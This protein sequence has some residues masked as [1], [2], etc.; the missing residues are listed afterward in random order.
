MSSPN[1]NSVATDSATAADYVTTPPKGTRKRFRTS[2][3]FGQH[4]A[5]VDAHADV[6][7]NRDVGLPALP[8][9]A[10][11]FTCGGLV[12][13]AADLHGVSFINIK[14]V[15][16][17]QRWIIHSLGGLIQDMPKTKLVQELRD[18][19][20]A[21]RGKRTRACFA[22]A[23]DGQ[24]LDAVGNV[25]VR[26]F[27]FQTVLKGARLKGPGMGVYLEHRL[28]VLQWF[29]T[30][31]RRD[32]SSHNFVTAQ[33]CAPE[34]EVDV[35]DVNSVISGVL[36]SR[37]ELRL[38]NIK[39]TKTRH[40]FIVMDT[41]VTT[42]VRLPASFRI[43]ICKVA[44]HHEELD[45]EARDTIETEVALQLERAQHFHDTGLILAE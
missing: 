38:N 22:V 27:T 12:V 18:A 7:G 30:E 41:K 13:D 8:E 16:D 25:T 5:D 33:Q 3:S 45:E 28:D 14:P 23:K 31:I 2:A 44:R 15:F 36:P 42:S 11:A 9:L 1:N 6:I 17:K 35:A 32:I 10:D 40:Q 29:L 34:D 4:D 20:A 19:I 37:D 39:Y 43:R 26:G 21:R 24:P